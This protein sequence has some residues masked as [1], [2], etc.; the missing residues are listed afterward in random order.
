MYM[1]QQLDYTNP[2]HIMQ[3][4]TSGV[5]SYATATASTSFALQGKLFGYKIDPAHYDQYNTQM[6]FALSCMSHNVISQ[7]VV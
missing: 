7:D 4:Q 3:A 6:D 5:H 1:L 2:T